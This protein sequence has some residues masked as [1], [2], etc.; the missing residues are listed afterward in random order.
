MVALNARDPPGL[1]LNAGI[2]GVHL[3]TQ[4]PSHFLK[5]RFYM[6]GCFACVYI[7]VLSSCSTHRGQKKATDLLEAEFQTSVSC[8]VDVG[9]RDPLEERPFAEYSFTV[10][11]DVSL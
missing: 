6:Y 7:C 1:P 4:P 2:K 9:N 5:I 10:C 11:E 3:Y 8:H